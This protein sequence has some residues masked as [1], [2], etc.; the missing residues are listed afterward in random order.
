MLGHPSLVLIRSDPEN[1]PGEMDDPSKTLSDSIPTLAGGDVSLASR[2]SRPSIFPGSMRSLPPEV[3]TIILRHLG[4]QE[5]L[6][7]ACLV[8]KSWSIGAMSVLWA[9]PRIS[10][11]SSL[12]QFA[13]LAARSNPY[14]KF[15]QHLRIKLV[16]HER[17]CPADPALLCLLAPACRNLRSLVLFGFEFGFDG[18]LYL[19]IGE[20]L[21]CF[22]ASCPK[23]EALVLHNVQITR[24]G[25]YVTRGLSR[26]KTL[27]LHL[28]FEENCQFFM[29]IAQTVNSLK[30]LDLSWRRV[31][32]G[33]L[34]AILRRSPDLHEL[35]LGLGHTDLTLRLIPALCPSLRCLSLGDSSVFTD[36]CVRALFESCP[37][38]EVVAV[39]SATVT[40]KLVLEAVDEFLPRCHT[41]LLNAIRY[42]PRQFPSD[43]P[44][45]AFFEKRRHILRGFATFTKASLVTFEFLQKLA[46]LCPV[47]PEISIRFKSPT[48]EYAAGFLEDCPVPY[49]ASIS[50]GPDECSDVVSVC[51]DQGR[52][53]QQLLNE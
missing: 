13:R 48:M 42:R 3:V 46:E 45:L 31:P 10:K 8:C 23:L 2:P 52:Y 37:Q 40:P 25:S 15:I 36:A 38:L 9:H 5:T 39:E 12:M 28:S 32:D 43:A 53:L 14:A 16:C 30:D 18:S 22:F 1:T 21:E 51:Y 27:Q 34:S 7:S 44:L 17:F 26:L 50:K 24:V 4:H 20:I 11:T 6:V 49:E 47:L 35:K 19:D 33:V 29:S 41:L